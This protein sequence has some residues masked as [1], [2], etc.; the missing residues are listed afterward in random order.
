MADIRVERLADLS[1]NYSIQVK[2][3][4]EIYIAGPPMAFPLI[5]QLYKYT[6]LAGAYPS[7]IIRDQRFDDMQ[8]RYGKDYQLEHV[9][10]ISKHAIQTADALVRIKAERNPKHLANIPPEKITKFTSAQRELTDIM[11]DRIKKGELSWT[12][13]PFPTDAMAQEAS[14]SLLEYQ[15][16]V[17]KACYAHTEDPKAEW[18]RI[19]V[20][21]QKIV[22]YL[23]KRAEIQFV[24]ED[25]DI[26]FNTKGRKWLN[27]DGR[28]NMPDGEVFTG[29]REDSAEGTIRFTYPA[30]YSGNEVEDIRLTFKNGKI[31]EAKAKKGEKLLNKMIQIDDGSDKMGE[32]AIGTNYEIATFTKDML[33]DEKMGGTIHMAVGR[34]IPETGSN[35]RS[36]IH[37]DMLKDMKNGGKIFADGELFYENGQFLI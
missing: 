33:F 9:P 29:P 8:F 37:W 31:V 4:Q 21:Q 3:N 28:K 14:M 32:I 22:D 30:I 23:T 5:E 7:V 11:A 17:Y 13:L 16:F 26:S 12:L 20:V 1:V 36:A 6:L 15:D 10:P 34:G 25:T 24:G 2:K 18:K 27:A 19:S 35:N